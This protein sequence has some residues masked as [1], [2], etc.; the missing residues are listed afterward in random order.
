[1]SSI[2]VTDYG[3]TRMV[4]LFSLFPGLVNPSS[5]GPGFICCGF[6]REPGERRSPGR[7]GTM[8]SIKFVYKFSG[9]RG[10]VGV[11]QMWSDSKHKHGTAVI[12]S[13]HFMYFHTPLKFLCTPLIYS[14]KWQCS[15]FTQMLELTKIADFAYQWTLKW[16]WSRSHERIC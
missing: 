7:L 5:D 2:F 9:I 11:K 6:V 15:H 4:I 13:D 16:G 14:V 8:G 12:C 1:M 10:E 3:H